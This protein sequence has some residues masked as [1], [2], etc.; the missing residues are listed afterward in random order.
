MDLKHLLQSSARP[1]VNT[2]AGPTSPDPSGGASGEPSG[3]MNVAS[4]E[5][6]EFTS[7]GKYTVDRREPLEIPLDRI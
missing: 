3:R 7:T 2:P 6:R 5:A 4:G 1:G